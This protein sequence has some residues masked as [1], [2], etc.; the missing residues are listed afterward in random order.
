MFNRGAYKFL[1][2]PFEWCQ[3]SFTHVQLHTHTYVDR[4]SK[5]G[6]HSEDTLKWWFAKLSEVKSLPPSSLYFRVFTSLPLSKFPWR[7]R[8]LH[9]NSNGWR[10]GAFKFLDWIHPEFSRTFQIVTTLLKKNKKKITHKFL[11]CTF[12]ARMGL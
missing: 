4:H 5:W 2:S 11:F 9:P 12:K 7:T 6:Q 3:L 1:I 10:R 8:Q